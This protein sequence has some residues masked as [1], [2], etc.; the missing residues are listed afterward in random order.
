MKNG[1][2]KHYDPITLSCEV[3]LNKSVFSKTL[4]TLEAVGS[5]REYK[6]SIPFDWFP[7]LCSRGR[8]KSEKRYR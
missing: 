3:Y 6:V 1:S 4:A 2:L 7:E 8:S 5:F